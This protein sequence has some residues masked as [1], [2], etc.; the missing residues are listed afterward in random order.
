MVSDVWVT[1]ASPLILLGKIGK[2]DLIT[3]IGARIVVP[4]GVAAEVRAGPAGDPARV[5][6]EGPGVESVTAVEKVDSLVATW[7]LGLGES[8]V[9]TLCRMSPGAEA[10]LDDRAARNCAVTLGI[11]V[12]GTL[13][14][15]VLAKRRGLIAEAKPLFHGLLDHGIRVDAAVI[16]TALR[17]AGER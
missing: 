3:R 14:L 5:W 6:I 10:I 1:N 8:H 7:D 2:I 16:E 13:A 9:L 15:I 12:R 4:E 11:R 17:L